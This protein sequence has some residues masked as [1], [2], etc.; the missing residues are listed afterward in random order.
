M[1][2]WQNSQTVIIVL[3]SILIL[4]IMIGIANLIED[5]ALLRKVIPAVS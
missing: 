4:K 3:L 5:E 2:N 1:S